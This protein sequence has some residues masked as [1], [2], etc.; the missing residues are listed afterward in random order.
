[1]EKFVDLRSHPLYLPAKTRSR[2]DHPVSVLLSMLALCNDD[3]DVKSLMRSLLASPHCT[4]SEALDLFYRM[5]VVLYALRMAPA[6]SLPLRAQFNLHH[7]L[8]AEELSLDPSPLQG[9]LKIVYSYFL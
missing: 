4:P 9:S 6:S 2:I 5:A 3:K 1:M 7:A 8:A